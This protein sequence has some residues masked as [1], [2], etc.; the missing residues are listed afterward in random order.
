[1][2]DASLVGVPFKR[3]SATQAR[4]VYTQEKSPVPFVLAMPGK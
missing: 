1:V 3:A 4:A 2:L